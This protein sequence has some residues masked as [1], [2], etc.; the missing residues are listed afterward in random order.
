MELR[1]PEVGI[2]QMLQRSEALV[3]V[4]HTWAASGALLA[5]GLVFVATG[6]FVATTV[7]LISL[8]APALLAPF[9]V[10]AK[11]ICGAEGVLAKVVG[12]V[13]RAGAHPVGQADVDRA[14][15]RVCERE[16]VWYTLGLE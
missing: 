3:P 6:S 8:L 14:A 2:F 1:S 16:W 11:A 15:R 5:A 4:R 9:Y 12:E 13:Y 7:A 10:P